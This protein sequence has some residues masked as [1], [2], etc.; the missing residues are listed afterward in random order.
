MRRA[1]EL[2]RQPSPG[3]LAAIA[4]AEARHAAA[5]A[6]EAAAKAA[7][8]VASAAHLAAMDATNTARREL[9]ELRVESGDHLREVLSLLRG[10]SPAAIDR[11]VVRADGGCLGIVSGRGSPRRLYIA[12]IE[13]DARTGE[14]KIRLSLN[15]V[16]YPGSAGVWSGLRIDWVEAE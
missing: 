14:S 3:D 8:E 4:D 10:R 12:S 1:E 7:A 6:V 9:A 16:V 2:L 11:I 13:R 15:G 5:V